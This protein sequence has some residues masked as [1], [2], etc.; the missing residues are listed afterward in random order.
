MTGP[1]PLGDLEY[2]YKQV[3][4]RL[5]R[6]D[7]RDGDTFYLEVLS[8]AGNQ[9]ISLEVSDN[10]D[11]PVLA[12]Y[13]EVPRPDRLYG[14]HVEGIEAYT[15][16]YGRMVKYINNYIVTDKTEII[17]SMKALEGDLLVHYP[18]NSADEFR[19]LVER[20]RRTILCLEDPITISALDSYELRVYILLVSRIISDLIRVYEEQSQLNIEDVGFAEPQDVATR[21]GDL[22][23][24][25]EVARI[26]SNLYSRGFLERR[27]DSYRPR[28]GTGALYE[29]LFHPSIDPDWKCVLYPYAIGLSHH[30]WIDFYAGMEKCMKL[31]K[32]LLIAEARS[33]DKIPIPAVTVTCR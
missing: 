10:Y 6:G 5:E 12:V 20:A 15:V 21:I 24:E 30:H 17:E 18:L 1:L 23:L 14:M 11:V 33:A 8:P 32:R 16:F 13:V 9:A 7:Y 19:E 22:L 4:S 27:G 2:I 28:F 29:A 31:H 26:V 3:A 25:D